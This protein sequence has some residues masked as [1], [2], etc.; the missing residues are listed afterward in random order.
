MRK[1]I[2]E[3]PFSGTL[4]RA[5]M[6]AVSGAF[7]VS[8]SEE[9]TP[10]TVTTG[11]VLRFSVVQ[12]DGT[13]G[14]RAATTRNT[15]VTTGDFHTSFGVFG[16]TYPN[17]EGW[18]NTRTPDYMY[19]VEYKKDD[20]GTYSSAPTYYLP[21]KGTG[22]DISFYAYAPYGAEGL[23]VPGQ[24]AGG[25]PTYEYTV[26]TDVEQQI[27]LCFTGRVEVK[28]E[29]ETA[30]VELPFQHALAAVSFVEGSEM[31]PGTI[32]GIT[33]TNLYDKGKYHIQEEEK[34]Y[35]ELGTTKKDFSRTLE[36]K[37]PNEPGTPI[38]DSQKP[39]I[40]MP[41]SVNDGSSELRVNY[42]DNSGVERTLTAPLNSAGGTAAFQF[43]EG[44]HFTF[45]INIVNGKLKIESVEATEWQT[46]QTIDVGSTRFYTAEK[47][48]TGDYFYSDGTWSDGGLR[49]TDPLKGEWVIADPKPKPVA[50]RKVVGI[51]YLTYDEHPERFR[52]A[53]VQKLREM[54]IGAHGLVLSVK[55]ATTAVA[56]AE[57][58]KD[59]ELVNLKTRADPYK[60][61]S[62]L[63]NCN[64]MKE[65]Y[66]N[67]DRY[68]AFKAAEAYNETCPVPNMTG[69]YLPASGQWWDILQYLSRVPWLASP[70]IQTSTEKENWNSGYEFRNTGDGADATTLTN[71]LDDLNA[72][73][74]GI[75]DSDK[76]ELLIGDDKTSMYGFLSSSEH[77][78]VYAWGCS[79]MREI[80]EK[81]GGYIRFTHYYAKEKEMYD[82]RPVLA[83]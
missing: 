54:G 55:N 73:M 22:T 27:D 20:T 33:L 77:K 6:L 36:V 78:Y 39:F 7:L 45:K 29:T 49:R 9:L 12:P 25:A 30:T 52:E 21:G 56:W 2:K 44:E 37:I 31:A 60:D 59:E 15:L 32:T 17:A 26:P 79:I 75:A 11:P 40:L 24:N 41:Q 42:T 74:S 13:D 46:G 65:K 34:N 83:F 8:C 51:V 58:R 38:T 72:W 80:I 61:I 64:L 66:G 63:S 68:P 3:R 53:E 1:R 62:G 70:T 57:E 50:D 10:D 35:W 28:R 4:R 14:Q 71:S 23:V 82:V 76:D 16:Y 43:S 69:W 19:N 48:K 5:A 81:D 47:L 67:L 18:D